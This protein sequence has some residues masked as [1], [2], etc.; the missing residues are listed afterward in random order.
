[1]GVLFPPYRG[2]QFDVAFE[3]TVLRYAVP[4]RRVDV[5]GHRVTVESQPGEGSPSRHNYTAQGV[6]LRSHTG[7]RR[8]LRPER[9]TVHFVQ[10]PVQDTEAR[11][12]R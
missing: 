3:Q 7:S 10:Q 1:M 8:T 5:F 6:I 4:S 11:R 12:A 9:V 2:P